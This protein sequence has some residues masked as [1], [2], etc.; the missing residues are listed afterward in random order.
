EVIRLVSAQ[1]LP[2]QTTTLLRA[3]LDDADP[4]GRF[5]MRGPVLVLHCVADGA[6]VADRHLLDEVFAAAV[7]QGQ[8][9]WLG[10]TMGILSALRDMKETRFQGEVAST[11]KKV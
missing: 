4:V 1:M 6:A 2:P 7:R 8:S 10:V 3:L 11:I 5:L 9:K